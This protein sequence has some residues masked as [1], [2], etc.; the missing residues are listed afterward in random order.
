MV[1]GTQRSPDWRFVTGRGWY[2]LGDNLQQHVAE[3][4][5]SDKPNWSLSFL[6]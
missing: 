4:R 6:L 5:R 2:T 1:R 3:K